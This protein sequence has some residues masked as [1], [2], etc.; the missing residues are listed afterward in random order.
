MKEG[1]KGGSKE[2]KDDRGWRI[3]H[4]IKDIKYGGL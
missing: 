2:K 4:N 1:R 3:I